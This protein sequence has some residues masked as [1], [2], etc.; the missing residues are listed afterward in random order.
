M[1]LIN[2]FK[3]GLAKLLKMNQSR[4]NITAI[5]GTKGYVA[6]E[7]FKNMPVTAKVD[8]YSY[9]VLLLEIISCRRSVEMEQSEEE[10]AILTDYAYDCYKR[11]A[12]DALVGDDKEALDDRGNLEKLVMIAIWCVQE[13]PRPT[14]R[15]VTQMLEGVVEVQA[16][17]YPS[18]FSSQI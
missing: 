8:V 2:I 1:S 10:K 9:G 14:M 5:R 4:T 7:W 13:D 16:P 12:V 3:L 11:G 15:K 6:V 17:P 18:S